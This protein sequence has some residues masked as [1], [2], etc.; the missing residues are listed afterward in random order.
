MYCPKCSCH[1]GADG[2]R[3]CRSCGFRLDGVVQLLARNGV[4]EGYVQPA[5]VAVPKA[6][7]P[8]KEGIRKGG[9]GLF[10]AI[11]VFPV[12][13][14]LCFAADSAGPLSIPALIFF[15]G[16]MR[17]LYAQL[18]EDAAPEP[19]TVYQPVI[20]PSVVQPF[21]TAPPQPVSFL[22]GSYQPPQAALPQ[23]SVPTTGNLTMPP[24]VTEQPTYPLKQS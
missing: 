24:S 15:S 19:P 3:F 8:R 4:P 5:P 11:A 6:K 9:K 20:Q 2:S 1:A 10:T 17:M 21:S 7:S 12:F 23:A 16:L 18:F 14:G 13:F 22:P